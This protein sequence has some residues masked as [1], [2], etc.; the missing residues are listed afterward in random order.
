MGAQTDTGA[1]FVAGVSEAVD[2]PFNDLWTIPGEAVPAVDAS[3][4]D[5]HALQDQDFLRA[6]LEDRAPLVDGDE[7]RKTVALIPA[8]YESGRALLQDRILLVVAFGVPPQD[9]VQHVCGASSGSC[10]FMAADCR[11]AHFCGR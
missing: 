3:T 1:T 9:A 7:G 5:Y 6:V 8:I 10:Q 4:V 2:P 11:A